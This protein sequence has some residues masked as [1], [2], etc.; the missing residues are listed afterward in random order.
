MIESRIV[1]AL[2]GVADQPGGIR[3]Q[4]E[5]LGIVENLA[6]EITLAVQFRLVGAQAGDVEHEAANLEKVS[7]LVVQSEGIDQN[8]DRGAIFTQEGGLEV[9]QG[10]VFLHQ[11]AMV[12]ALLRRNVQL[13][14]DVNLKQFL[15]AA[16]AEHAHHGVVDFDKASGRSTEEESFLD[17]VEEFAISPLGFAPV[18]NI[19]QNMDRLQ[20]FSRRSMHP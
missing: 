3:Y 19:F 4:D 16:V 12:E 8:V 13:C 10:A 2:V 7:H 11:L 9:S 6:G 14:R 15:T 5:A 18:G 20:P 1:P 17:V